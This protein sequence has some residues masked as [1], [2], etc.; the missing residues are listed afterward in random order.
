MVRLL[1]LPH[2]NDRDDTNLSLLL[3]DRPTNLITR[4]DSWAQN[5]PRFPILPPL[6]LSHS[7]EQQ[8]W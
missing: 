4:G 5:S 1:L 6:P 7:Q 2:D 3:R 8:R